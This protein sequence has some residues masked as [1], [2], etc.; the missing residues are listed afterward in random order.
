MILM[1]KKILVT[2]IYI[3]VKFLELV[4]SLQLYIFDKFFFRNKK[5]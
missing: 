2:I 3:E 5:D 4:I 1:C